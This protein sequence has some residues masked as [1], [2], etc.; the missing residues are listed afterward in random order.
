MRMP[1]QEVSRAC[2]RDHDP[3]PR[4]AFAARPTDQLHDGLGACT[5]E[6]AEHFPPAPEQRAQQARDGEHHVT[7]RHGQEQ[8][9]VQPLAHGSCFFFSH[10]GQKLRPRQEN[11]TS[12]L[13]RHSRTKAVRSHVRRG[14]TSRTPAALAR[15]PDAGVRASVN[16]RAV[17]SSS[18]SRTKGHR[19]YVFIWTANVGTVEMP[20]LGRFEAVDVASSNGLFAGFTIDTRRTRCTRCCGRRPPSSKR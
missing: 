10:E 1:L 16:Q 4:V 8:F 7:V 9:L 19:R 5:S 15:P 11:A 2:D 6:L 20:S 13:L 18:S 12:T 14:R 17:R 3:R